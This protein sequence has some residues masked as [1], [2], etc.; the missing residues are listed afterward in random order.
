MYFPKMDSTTADFSRISEFD[1]RLVTVIQD[2]VMLGPLSWN[3]EAMRT[4]LKGVHQKAIRLPKIEYEH[5][6]YTDQITELVTIIKELGT[7]E[8]P[9]LCFLRDTA[10]S[11][12]DAY[13]ILQGAGTTDVTTFSRKLYGSPKDTPEGYEQRSIDIAAYFLDLA[14]RYKFTIP[15]EPLIYSAPQFRKA[16]LKQIGGTINQHIDPVQVMIDANLTARASAGSNYVK[17]RKGARFS[18]VD[19]DQLLHHEVF[20]HTLTYINGRKQPVLKTLGYAA[21]RTT[22]TQE[23]L[24]IFAEYINRGMELVRLKRIALRIKAINLAEKGADLVDLFLFYKRYGSSDEESYYSAMRI[25][26]GG[27]PKG[28]IVFYKDNVYLTGFLEITNFLKRVM[29][30]GQ[31]YGKALLFCG[32]LT[33]GDIALL[34]EFAEEGGVA[35]PTYLPDWVNNTGALAAH[36][37]C[38]DLVERFTHQ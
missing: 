23:G 20:T 2:F 24:A 10:H 3:K 30:S 7:D 6:D 37:A 35:P 15:E 26:R 12:L 22:A 19:L 36:L 28:G 8:H 25:F 33:I 32:K 18:Q 27:Y 1:A 4:F 38:N 31:L 11:Y 14:D 16:L 13:R 34:R 9:A 29:R 21:P 17:L 5:P